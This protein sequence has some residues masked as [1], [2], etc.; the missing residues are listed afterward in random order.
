ME[1][2]GFNPQALARMPGSQRS[3]ANKD[4]KQAARRIRRRRWDAGGDRGE[5]C[6]VRDGHGCSVCFGTVT[7]YFCGLGKMPVRGAERES[8]A[9]AYTALEFSACLIRLSAGPR[10]SSA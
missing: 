6:V 8:S 2:P 7:A 5:G 1:R 3:G 9:P 4:K 10:R